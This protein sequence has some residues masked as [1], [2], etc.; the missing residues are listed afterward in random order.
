MLLCST[1]V[2]TLPVCRYVTTYIPAY[3]PP[4]ITVG[5]TVYSNNPN[6]NVVACYM[7]YDDELSYYVIIK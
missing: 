6:N 3:R 1:V 2:T 5:G 4:V 7:I